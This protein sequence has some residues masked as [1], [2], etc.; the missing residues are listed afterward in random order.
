MVDQWL[1]PLI[2]NAAIRRDVNKVLRGISTRYTIEAAATLA[3]HATPLLIAWGTDD[4]FFSAANAK[5]LASEVPGARLEW[6]P[7]AAAFVTIDQPKRLGELIA[8]FAS[9][10]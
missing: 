6:I 5:R 3:D 7:D 4:R 10:S 8:E 2:G 9:G 1:K